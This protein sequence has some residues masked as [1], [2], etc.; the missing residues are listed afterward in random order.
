MPTTDSAVMIAGTGYIL[1]DDVAT[2]TKPTLAALTT[3]A[4]DTSVP[5]AGWDILGHTSL[6]NVLA[7]GQEGGETEVKGSWQN[8]SLREI[9][10]SEA[11]DYLTVNALQIKDNDVLSLY[12]GGGD[13]TVADEFSLPDSGTPQE[14][15]MLVV[16]IDGAEPVGLFAPKASIRREGEISTPSDDFVEL[17]LRFTLLK[18]TGAKKATWI[19]AGLG[20]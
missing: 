5:P 14:R 13:A 20:V 19:A 9:V 2:A 16:F 3:F 12:Y 1:T 17:P 18:K 8:K 10:T 4:A 15:A 11:V 6:Q 7:F